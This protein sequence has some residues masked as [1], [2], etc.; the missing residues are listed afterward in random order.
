MTR[1]LGTVFIVPQSGLAYSNIGGTASSISASATRMTQNPECLVEYRERSLNTLNQLIWTYRTFWASFR[2]DP[3]N[4][5]IIISRP[6]VLDSGNQPQYLAGET[7][8]FTDKSPPW[9]TNTAATLVPNQPFKIVP[10]NIKALLPVYEGTQEAVY[11][12][13][14]ANGTLYAGESEAV[15]KN[16]YG[17]ERDLILHVPDWFDNRDQSYAD[18]Y[19]KEIWASVQQ[20]QVEGGFAWVNGTPDIYMTG[21]SKE[22]DYR[23]LIDSLEIVPPSNEAVTPVRKLQAFTIT[24][25]ESCNAETGSGVEDCP[26]ILSATEVRYQ[27]GRKP[28]TVATFSTAKP[29]AAMPMHDFHSF[30][31]HLARDPNPQ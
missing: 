30:E 16:L 6:V 1:I 26:L 14:Y 18:K 10:Y 9:D 17:I 8:V 28:Y 27:S 29:R 19:A 15:V 22:W 25:T 13:H 7:G 24:V 21:T 4:N 2:I 20:P 11:P 23:G 5:A 12:H 3:V 31:E